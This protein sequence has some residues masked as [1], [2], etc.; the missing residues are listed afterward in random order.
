VKI[1]VGNNT[2]RLLKPGD[3]PPPEEPPPPG[4]PLEPPPPTFWTPDRVAQGMARAFQMLGDYY[5]D[6]RL[7]ASDFELDIAGEVW[8]PVCQDLLPNIG[9]TA[10][11]SLSTPA[12]IVVAFLVV[13]AM[14]L[15]RLPVILQHVR[16]DR[17]KQIDAQQ[18]RAQQ[19]SPGQPAPN[20]NVVTHPA[21]QPGPVGSGQL[22]RT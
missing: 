8:A 11:N 19:P 9:G 18:Q 6:P 20:P 3:A 16:S 13:A 14:L 4:T 22:G 17:Q 15:F 5:Q 12:K 2:A 21:F 7:N 10:T 1:E